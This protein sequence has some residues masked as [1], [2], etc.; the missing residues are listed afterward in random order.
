MTLKDIAHIRL[1]NQQIAAK[2][3]QNPKSILNYMG[4]MQAQDYHMAKWAIGSRIHKSTNKQIEDAINKGE[5]IRTHVLRPTW[6]FVSSDNI[7]WMLQLTA[8]QIKSTLK[9]RH[10]E[11][12]LTDTILTKS[13]TIIEKALMGNKHLTRE[14]LKDT[15]TKTKIATDNNRLSH[16]L[17][18]AELNSLI[19]SGVIKENKQTYALLE[20]RIPKTK[21][22]GREE[23]LKKLAHLYFS[24]HGPATLHDFVWWS[25]LS[26][27]EARLALEMIKHNCV[28]QTIDAKTY[29]FLKNSSVP[30]QESS[31]VYLLPAFDEF[32]ISYRDRS[33]T[34]TIADHNKAVSNNGI[35]RP[36]IVI[37]GSVTGLWKR[38]EKKE[39]LLI[40]TAF[41]RA[42]TKAEKN[43]IEEAAETIGQFLSKE[44]E[45]KHNT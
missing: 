38:T 24:S 12:E 6:H 2:T 44:V 40:E 20:E 32:I 21:K 9:S 33:A 19:C 7:H 13:N 31:S 26:V 36:T 3:Y 29:W 27:T 37:N 11:L 15:L 22:Y 30:S 43:L 18:W 4:A 10:K 16:L 23:S 25:G 14:E 17:F 42:H 28:S 34:L 1:I 35:F 41:F 45:V 8:P 5:I 39:K